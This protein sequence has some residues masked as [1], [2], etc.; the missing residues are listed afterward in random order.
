MSRLSVFSIYVSYFSEKFIKKFFEQH[1][2]ELGENV[3]L[4]NSCEAAIKQG[5]FPD[6][7]IVNIGKNVGFSAANNIG[8]K[9]GVKFKPDYFLIINPDVLLPPC[10][11][12]VVLDIIESPQFSDVGIFTV[13][14][15][16]YDFEQEE[17]TGKVDSLG[18][19]HKWYG[20]WFDVS[21]GE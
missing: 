2:D 17:A 21:Q 7:N 4:I 8:I 11:L 9:L 18:I 1:K 14:L 19:D 10:W 3:S 6:F 15:L 5:D 12:N 16:G 20:R 13:P